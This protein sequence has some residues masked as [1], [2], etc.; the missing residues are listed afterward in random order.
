[1]L[2]YIG[3]LK[4]NYNILFLNLL[5][6]IFFILYIIKG[7]NKMKINISYKNDLSDILINIP[8]DT[9]YVS[10]ITKIVKDNNDE[11]IELSPTGTVTLDILFKEDGQQYI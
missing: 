10:V 6:K 7:G 9:V 8:E 1:M 2:F 4:V 5:E 3:Q 11:P